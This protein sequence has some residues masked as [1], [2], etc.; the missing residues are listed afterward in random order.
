[1]KKLYLLPTLLLLI[2]TS[3]T[4]AQT[5]LSAGDIAFVMVNET[6]NTLNSAT[7]DDN[8]S[9]VLLKNIASG[10]QI[11]FTDFGWRS[12]AAAFQTA[13]P[14]GASTGAV[15]DG[16]VTWTANSNLSYGTVIHMSVRN[17]PSVNIGTISGTTAAYNSTVTAPLYYVSLSAAAGE[18]V[19]AFQGTFANPTLITAIRLNSSWSTSLLNCEYTPS[20]CVQPSSL[21]TSGLSFLWGQVGGNGKLKSSVT[22]TGTKAADLANIYNVANWDLNTTTAYSNTSTLNLNNF[23]TNDFNLYPNPTTGVISIQF[24][25]EFQETKYTIYD[26]V[27]RSLVSGN[28]NKKEEKISLENLN[29]GVY[30]IEFKNNQGKFV[31]K[32]I[33]E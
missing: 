17:N 24:K 1:M 22:L 23:Q 15:T 25:N 11:S 32:I 5:T 10:T 7:S 27:G 18:S 8:V 33:K 16:V 4:N 13:N 19:I 31:E 21:N 14:C 3:K 26:L 29:K 20:S 12:D 9:F 6:D 2:F 30:L 28:L